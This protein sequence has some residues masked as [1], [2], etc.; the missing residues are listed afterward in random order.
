MRNRSKRLA[1]IAVCIV[2]AAL[3]LVIGV[4]M[5]RNNQRFD[6]WSAQLLEH[7]VPPGATLTDS[8][9]RFGLLWGNGNH[10]DR[11]AWVQVRGDLSR[12]S[13]E[14]HYLLAKRAETPAEQGFL[15]W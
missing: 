13:L 10:C 15:K 8:G 12:D 3:V 1:I 2:L 4:T 7:P 5:H 9:R 14:Q 6:A 11:E